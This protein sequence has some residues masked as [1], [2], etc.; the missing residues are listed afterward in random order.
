MRTWRPPFGGDEESSGESYESYESWAGVNTSTEDSDE[1]RM[2]YDSDYGEYTESDQMTD[3]D[4][5]EEYW[6]RV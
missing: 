4:F 3:S 2:M 6:D 1:E 5:G